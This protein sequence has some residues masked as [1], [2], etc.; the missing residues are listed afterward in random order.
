MLQIA[1]DHSKEK[2]NLIN[3]I[4]N[5]LNNTLTLYNRYEQIV[6]KINITILAG[7][8]QIWVAV[9]E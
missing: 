5:F 3:R 2:I 7:R 6:Y 9:Q 4:E 8:N 1:I